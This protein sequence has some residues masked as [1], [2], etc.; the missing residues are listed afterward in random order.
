MAH[1]KLTEEEKVH[2]KTVEDMQLL[3]RVFAILEDIEGRLAILE[4]KTK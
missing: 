3:K 4:T 2:V 1:H